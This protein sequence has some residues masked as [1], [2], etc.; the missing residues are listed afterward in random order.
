MR[1]FNGKSAASQRHVPPK[2]KRAALPDGRAALKVENSCIC[3]EP[4]G[5]QG[6]S[7]PGLGR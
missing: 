4:F 5:S 3:N 2:Q 7:M 6:R 1:G